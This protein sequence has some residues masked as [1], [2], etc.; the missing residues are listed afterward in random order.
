MAW[1]FP[2]D[3]WK[4]YCALLEQRGADVLA[5]VRL[6]LREARQRVARLIAENAACARGKPAAREAATAGRRGAQKKPAAR[7]LLDSLR[8]RR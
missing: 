2:V 7:A 6:P 5:P 8:D 3:D 4:S 1:A